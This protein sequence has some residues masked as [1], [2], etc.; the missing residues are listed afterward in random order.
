MS[1]LLLLAIGLT[2]LAVL[3]V[4]S[5]LSGFVLAA[6]A[7]APWMAA[8]NAIVGASAFVALISGWWLVLG[9]TS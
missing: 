5:S 9:V 1:A 8:A 7:H 2:P 6:L 3:A 4:A